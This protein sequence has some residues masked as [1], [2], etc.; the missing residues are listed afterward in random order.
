[1]RLV[2]V[3]MVMREGRMCKVATKRIKVGADDG[4]AIRVHKYAG[5][6]KW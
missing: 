5:D 6:A 2:L 3:R 4:L 1:M